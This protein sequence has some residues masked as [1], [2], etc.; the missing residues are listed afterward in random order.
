MARLSARN[1]LARRAFAAADSLFLMA[2]AAELAAVDIAMMILAS[3]V[4]SVSV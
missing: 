4:V 3:F 2:W 1:A